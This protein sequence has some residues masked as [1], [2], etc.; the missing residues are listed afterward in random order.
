MACF[1]FHNLILIALCECSSLAACGS[2]SFWPVGWTSCSE[3]HLD[4]VEDLQ[5]LK[6]RHHRTASAVKRLQVVS[7]LPGDFLGLWSKWN[8][9]CS[10]F[11]G[12]LS[13]TNDLFFSLSSQQFL[14]GGLILEAVPVASL[15]LLT[16]QRTANSFFISLG[17]NACEEPRLLAL[18]TGA[19]FCATNFTVLTT[20]MTQ[21]LF[22]CEGS[23]PASRWLFWNLCLFFTSGCF[24]T[25]HA[26]Q[27]LDFPSG[28]PSLYSST[29]KI[30]ENTNVGRA[31]AE[32]VY[33]SV[34]AIQQPTNFSNSSSN[35]RW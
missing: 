28:L 31:S 12:T 4:S 23:T 14:P 2:R 29:Y 15:H 10:D 24:K 34:D 6:H 3:L 19:S 17:I 33:R 20:P 27:K 25:V 35:S 16:N 13:G 26:L 30:Q 22:V 18:H 7:W 1:C 11:F 5:C 8:F 21:D 9:N 32:R